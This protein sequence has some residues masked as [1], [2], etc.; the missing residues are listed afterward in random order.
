[1]ATL[2]SAVI[3]PA[4]SLDQLAADLADATRTLTTVD[5][6][7]FVGHLTLG[8]M[9]P[10]ATCGLV[11][12]PFEASFLLE[13]VELVASEQVAGNHRYETLHTW[14]APLEH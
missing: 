11:G 5:G 7:P 4:G 2:G 8:R 13:R 9:R 14:P 1:M 6:R 12:H 10:G 3:V